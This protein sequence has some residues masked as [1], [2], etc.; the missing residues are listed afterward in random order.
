MA[1]P[2]ISMRKI[3]DVL[4]LWD[5]AGLSYRQIA[6]SLQIAYGAVAWYLQQICANPLAGGKRLVDY[7]DLHYYPQD[8][9]DAPTDVAGDADDAATAAR[10]LRSLKELYDPAWV[11]ES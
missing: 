2:R 6:A 8:P 4:R 7:L 1:N 10:R 5:T 3:K 9:N 11:S